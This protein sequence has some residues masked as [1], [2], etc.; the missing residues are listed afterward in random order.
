ML[1]LDDI[2]DGLPLR[3]AARL[4]IKLSGALKMFQGG[5]VVLALLAVQDVISTFRV[6]GGNRDSPRSVETFQVIMRLLDRVWERGFSFSHLRNHTPVGDCGFI[7][8]VKRQR[9]LK[10]LHRSGPLA[11]SGIGQG[12][13][14]EGL[15]MRGVL[16]QNATEKLNP[17]LEVPLVQTLECFVK[18][19]CVRQIRIQTLEKA[20]P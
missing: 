5:I 1:R 9:A 14:P 12:H 19:L 3:L 6:A 17:F 11:E 15:D 13:V 7:S 18:E 2:H 10:T 16:A 8:R 20:I 4:Q